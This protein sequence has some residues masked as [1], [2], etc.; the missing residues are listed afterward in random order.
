MVV[1]QGLQYEPD[2]EIGQIGHLWM[3]TGEAFPQ[4]DKLRR[5]EDLRFSIGVLTK[6]L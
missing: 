3:G 1:F 6:C 4:T 2:A 5:V